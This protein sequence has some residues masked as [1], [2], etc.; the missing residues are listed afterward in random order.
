MADFNRIL[1]FRGGALGDFILTLPALAALR[2]RW[3]ES[4]LEL[5]GYPRHAALGVTAEL[6]NRVRSLDAAR[7]AIY[8]QARAQLPPDEIE[9]IRS[10]DLIISYLHDPAG[11]LR[12]HLKAAGAEN[13]IAV[14]PLVKEGHAA[15]HFLRALRE[16]IGD[17]AGQ[18]PARKAR[19]HFIKCGKGSVLPWKKFHRFLAAKSNESP[20]A[21][22]AWPRVLKEPARRRL[23]REIGD[24][25]ALMIHPGSGSP[26]KNWPAEKFAAL[27]KEIK[28]R[29]K[30]EPVIL[31]GEADQ[32]AIRSLKAAWP[33]G[34]IFNNLPLEEAASLL[35]VAGG[36][37]GNDSGITHLAAALGL[38]VVAFFGPTDPAVWAP[39]GANVL[40]IKFA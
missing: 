11:C 14:S 26:A 13:V 24:K 37:V 34:R 31:G 1:V 20:A 3:P 35:S 39:R 21:L 17:Q 10:F 33:A 16:I 8:F 28:T 18:T 36:Y 32:A 6:I 19:P 30:F 15:D 5:V 4:Y 29:T 12:R 2:R 38:P 27:A 40:V 25:P 22:L 9:Y 23:F 7:W